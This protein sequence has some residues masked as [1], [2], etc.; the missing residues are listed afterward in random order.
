[1]RRWV[2]VVLGIGLNVHVVPAVKDCRAIALDDAAGH[3]TARNQLVAAILGD[4]EVVLGDI[5]TGRSEQVLA[6][7]RTLSN[8]MGTRVRIAMREEVVTGVAED[9]SSSGEL[10]LRN[11]DGH[12]LAI[13]SGSLTVE[14]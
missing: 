14:P 11:E 7:W 1:M 13:A 9:V 4:L 8:H 12:L 10:L 3:P 5:E 2:R 6:V